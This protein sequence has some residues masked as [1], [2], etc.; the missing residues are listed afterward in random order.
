[1]KFKLLIAFILF[2][3]AVKAQTP[4]VTPKQLKAAEDVLIASQADVQ[5]K[6]GITTMLKQ[7]SS[8]L[9]EDK[10]VKFIEVMNA[11]VAKYISWD[12]MKDQLAS[13]YAQEFT[14]KELTDLALFYRS[15][16]GLKLNQKQPV[17][18]QKGAALG[19]QAVQSH[20]VELQQ[21][22]Q[23]AFKEK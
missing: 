18:L 17:L 21:M 7:A 8:S 23:E 3:T 11:F 13:L 10:R 22:M 15:P 5:F 16:L 14:E 20:Q 4:A 1:M 12:S 9:P 19:Q 2:C 6:A